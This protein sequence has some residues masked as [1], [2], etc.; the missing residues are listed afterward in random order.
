VKTPTIHFT[1]LANNYSHVERLIYSAV[2]AGFTES[3][4][5]ILWNSTVNEH[6]PY[7]VIKQILSETTCDFEIVCHQDIR[8]ISGFGKSQLLA[9]LEDI[10]ERTSVCG[11]AG[12][13]LNGQ[14]KS[15]VLDGIQWPEGDVTFTDCIWNVSHI[16]ECFICFVTKNKTSVSAGLSG[17]HCYGTD[18]CL[19][20]LQRK[21]KTVLLPFRIKH[22][23]M[24]NFDYRFNESL[25]ALESMWSGRALGYAQREGAC[26]LAP[27][28]VIRRLLSRV[29]VRRCFHSLIRQSIV[30]FK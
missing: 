23:S 25:K 10:P 26:I 13:L 15:N 21:Y 30:F 20:A 29:R 12:S 19:N 8:F 17:F 6:E 4:F 5:T 9:T 14:W 28:A 2:S 22:L 16:D 27:S 1:V 7:S 3:E 11:V 18:V 24:G